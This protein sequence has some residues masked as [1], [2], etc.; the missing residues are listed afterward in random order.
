M[1]KRRAPIASIAIGT[2]LAVAGCTGT[3]ALPAEV[4]ATP[5][6]ALS[7]AEAARPVQPVI[8]TVAPPIAKKADLIFGAGYESRL[9]GKRQATL[10][11][12]TNT[13]AILTVTDSQHHVL[14]R[15]ITVRL[16]GFKSTPVAV[17]YVSTA[18]T[19]LA[20]APPF[21]TDNP[22]D[23][24]ILRAAAGQSAHLNA[25][26][27]AMSAHAATDP[28]YLATPTPTETAEVTA[29]AKDVASTLKVWSDNLR[30]ATPAKPSSAMPQALL[31]GTAGQTP[32]GCNQGIE[33]VE[34]NPA[35]GLCLI[36]GK[37][38]DGEYAV[39]YTNTSPSWA[40]VYAYDD[41]TLPVWAI[42]PHTFTLPT[43]SDIR[44]ALIK[45]FTTAPLKV[46]GSRLGRFLP[47][48][49]EIAPKEVNFFAGLESLVAGVNH[50]ATG[51]FTL[52]AK[53]GAKKVYVV[54]VGA[55]QGP[56]DVLPAGTDLASAQALP[57]LLTSWS[58]IGKPLLNL[59]Q[60]TAETE[61]P[62]TPS[63]L[64]TSLKNLKS[65]LIEANAEAQM[66]KFVNMLRD[67]KYV[68]AIS[69]MSK[70]VEILLNNKSGTLLTALLNLVAP[71]LREDVIETTLKAI[72]RFGANLIPGPGW[73]KAI[74][75]GAALGA[76]LVM[77]IISITKGLAQVA[78]VGGYNA[79]KPNEYEVLRNF[80]WANAAYLD[81]AHDYFSRSHESFRLRG[82]Q[83]V[84]PPLPSSGTFE[85]KLAGPV[86]YGMVQGKPSAVAI[87]VESI[88]GNQSCSFGN[89]HHFVF[90]VASGD[91]V[92]AAALGYTDLG[93]LGETTRA[94]WAIQGDALE[95]YTERYDRPGWTR[96]RFAFGTFLTAADFW[97]SANLPVGAKRLAPGKESLIQG[98]PPA[99][100][101]A[102]ITS[103]Q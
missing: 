75:D 16:P 85:F 23:L 36:A 51:E 25:L 43:V 99:G 37:K 26:S 66:V 45:D 69:A 40:F 98:P 3:P 64:K 33:A 7:A 80:D 42:H 61:E 86:L 83:L 89:A 12:R 17:D 41:P 9:D 81:I 93:C 94:R 59:L 38:T 54:T 53:Q 28:N 34:S 82:G 96:V 100:G 19:R 91:K 20:T 55:T 84:L 70:I 71:Q 11:T 65:A 2:V 76:N 52:T 103:G 5:V 22:L 68:D 60:G 57:A 18:F 48:L 15:A 101:A 78:N 4:K 47:F 30:A 44:D 73:V 32:S 72:Q 95:Q 46:V 29:L 79:I 39:N 14:A 27:A 49:G 24:T 90:Q 8:A 35:T 97:S 10:P 58:Q 62:L 87:V 13:A 1:M 6:G 50:D 31:S 77:G 67:K 63:S 88:G 74:F 21:L 102:W 56:L 92:V